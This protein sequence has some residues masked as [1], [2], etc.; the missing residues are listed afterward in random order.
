MKTIPPEKVAS[1][2]EKL[3]D[4]GKKHF[5]TEL[6]A[7]LEK[8]AKGVDFNESSPT[9]M[10]FYEEMKDQFMTARHIINIVTEASGHETS[11]F[12]QLSKE[13]VFHTLKQS[14]TRLMDADKKLD[15]MYG[16]LGLLLNPELEPTDKYEYSPDSKG[17][18]WLS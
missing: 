13:S 5:T 18:H 15:L 9:S 8:Q 3:N 6:K 10:F 14:L 2:Y 17:K 4:R 11:D 1:L 7:Q 12:E 16:E